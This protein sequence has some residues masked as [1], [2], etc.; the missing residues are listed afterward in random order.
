MRNPKFI[1]RMIEKHNKKEYNKPKY[2][3]EDLYI[4][5]L[6]LLKNATFVNKDIISNQ[7]DIIKEFAIFYYDG[8]EYTHISSKA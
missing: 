3:I 1:E 2:N 6:V 4:G 5:K 8:I 7:C